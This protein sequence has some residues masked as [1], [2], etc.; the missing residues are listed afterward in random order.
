MNGENPG[1]PLP[2]GPDRTA[3]NKNSLFFKGH[4]GSG[5]PL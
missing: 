3:Y 2:P 5:E 1:I 4:D